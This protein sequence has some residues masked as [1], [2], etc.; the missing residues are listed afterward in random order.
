M[1]PA[2]RQQQI[3]REIDQIEDNLIPH[4]SQK[5]GVSE[6]TIRRDLKVLEE[7]GHI[8]RTHGGAVR[9]RPQK[10]DLMASAW[11]ERQAKARRRKTAI[12]RYAAHQLVSE[13]DIIVLEGGTTI[14]AMAEYLARYENLT[15]VTNGHFTTS[16]LMRWLPATNNIIC[17][18]GIL[19]FQ[20]ASFAGPVTRRF[21]QDFHGHRAFLSARGL[22]LE[23]G[24]TD[25]QMVE[26]EV[27]Q[28]MAAAVSEVIMLIDSSKFGVNSLMTVLPLEQITTLVTDSQASDNMLEAL[29]TRGVEVVIAP[30]ST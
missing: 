16:A 17:T 12:A 6:M 21:L 30:D 14:T 25:P 11:Q 18:G 22:S 26:I 27:K 15:V 5:Y 19:Q 8:I 2:E 10:S 24:F 9:W 4:L 29:Q 3:L 13:G 7:A 1:N 28:Q 20:T 23:A